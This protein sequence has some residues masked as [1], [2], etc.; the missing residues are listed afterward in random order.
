M[1]MSSGTLLNNRYRLEEKLGQGGMGA[2]YLAFDTALDAAVAV[3]VNQNPAPESSTQ[4]LRE[5]RL[6]ASLR[7]P[8]LPRVTD[9]FILN[10]AQY[11]VMDY[12]PGKDLNAVLREEG[13][14]PLEK[15][16]GWVRQLSS[17]LTYLHNQNPPVVHRDI[18]PANVRLT[19]DGAVMLVDFG[20]AKVFD[21]N[22]QATAT[23][24]AGYT[25]GYAPPEQYGGAVRTGP[26]SDQYSL[27][28]L[29]YNLLTAQKPADSV[30]R[31]LGIEQL[32]PA[33]QHNPN[34]P[35]YIQAAI[36]RALSLR[37]NDRFP[38]VADF[39]HALTNPAATS[40]AYSAPTILSKP[41]EQTIP[42]AG[43]PSGVPWQA[44]TQPQQ[45][46]DATIA[47]QPASS[48]IA[49][50]AEAPAP[51]RK[52]LNKWVIIGGIG[53]VVLLGIGAVALLLG[54][55]II[56]QIAGKQPTQAAPLVI[57]QA[58]QTPL[59]QILEPTLTASSTPPPTTEPS[60]TPLLSTATSAPTATTAPSPT[61]ASTDTPPPP[62]PTPPGIGGSG[63]LAFASDRGDGATLQIW[64]MRVSLNDQGQMVVGNL[65]QI[66]NTPGNK[67]QPAWSPDGKRLLYVASGGPDQ[68]L[69]IW[70]INADGSGEPK[71]LTNLK[72]NETK[73]AWS[74]DGKWIAYTNDSRSDGVP[75]VSIIRPDGSERYRLSYDQMEYDP[76]WSPKNELTFVMNS[77]G[78][79]IVFTRGQKDPKTGA[80]PTRE[81]YV[82]PTRFDKLSFTDN[83][84]QAA[85]PAWSPD[86]MWLTYTRIRGKST[87]ISLSRFPIRVPANDVVHLTDSGKDTTPSFAPDGQWIAFRS[88]RDG[89][90]EIYIMRSTGQTQTNLTNDPAKDQDPAWM[91][92]GN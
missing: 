79:Q 25:P 3:K 51:R 33:R 30:Q 92:I 83:L 14:Q 64:T 50:P 69:D 34:V 62:S 1:N 17:A 66:T 74:P 80:E 86:G 41:A 68:K 57:A 84:G 60:S 4:F 46:M 28:A 45:A 78:A 15:V 26:Y 61:T 31:A 52:G 5:A 75:Q 22:Q 73:P 58:S 53:L 81:Y 76:T 82:T 40:E 24:A 65:K 70:M 77:A 2:V 44:Q 20:I 18:K 39:L 90:A 29:L 13:V 21:A 9:Y 91:P 67:T 54:G 7:H 23:G 19:A 35:D 11:L 87:N 71:D 27:A 32:V 16:L 48:N 47:L 72:G 88:S 38:S 59:P 8:N 56:Q 42:S 85:E 49:F 10:D 6:L 37:P 63:L 43:M 55:W 36:E 89:N 12:I